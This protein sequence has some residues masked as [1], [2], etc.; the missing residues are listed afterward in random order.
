MNRNPAGTACPKCHAPGR[1]VSR[2]FRLDHDG[3]G[4]SR[5]TVHLWLTCDSCGADW[6]R[7]VRRSWSEVHGRAWRHPG[8]GRAKAERV[9]RR[10]ARRH[11]DYPAGAFAGRPE[12]FAEVVREYRAALGRHN[13]GPVAEPFAREAIERARSRLLMHYDGRINFKYSKTRQ[14]LSTP[15]G[16]AAPR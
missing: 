8:E 13:F 15:G 11:F 12:V 16:D 9:A 14:R 3:P 10:L 1:E 6:E 5:A 4:A 7:D 2:R